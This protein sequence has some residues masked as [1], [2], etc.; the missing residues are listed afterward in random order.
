[1]PHR[2]HAIPLPGQ[3]DQLVGFLDRRRDGLLDEEADELVALARER[4]R[5]CAVVGTATDTASTSGSASS[6]AS[7]VG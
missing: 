3:G 2:Q 6:S 5:V 1:V 4:D 7:T